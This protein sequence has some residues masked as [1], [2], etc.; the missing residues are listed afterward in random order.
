MDQRGDVITGPEDNKR[1]INEYY[2]QHYANSFVNL[3]EM[4]KFLKS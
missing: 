1:I 2:G 4:N 3:D